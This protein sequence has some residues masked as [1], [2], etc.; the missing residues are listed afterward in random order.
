[1]SGILCRP[2][3]A[4][5]HLVAIEFHKLDEK[6]YDRRGRIV[7]LIFKKVPNQDYQKEITIFAVRAL[8]SI[9]A[10]HFT[11]MDLE[12]YEYNEMNDCW[13]YYNHPLERHRKMCMEEDKLVVAVNHKYWTWPQIDVFKAFLESIALLYH[14]PFIHID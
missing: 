8:T 14:A 10:G 11:L 7:S 12:E 6:R 3:Q 2:G 4:W 1:M 5:E 13:I 9:L